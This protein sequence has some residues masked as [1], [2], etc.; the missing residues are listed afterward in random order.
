MGTTEINPQIPIII[1]LRKKFSISKYF[2]FF[3]KILV[4]PLQSHHEWPKGWSKIP[5]KDKKGL[6]AYAKQRPNKPYQNYRRSDT[7]STSAQTQKDANLHNILRSRAPV[8]FLKTHKTGGST[9][10]NLLF[11]MG[12]KD[13]A[14]FA[15]PYYTYQFSYPDKY[16][17]VTVLC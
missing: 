8:V 7:Q 4:F 3:A 10:Q 16:A 15:F 5:A 17:T 12:E 9:V 13:R 6:P 1:S 2:I 14:T 11:R